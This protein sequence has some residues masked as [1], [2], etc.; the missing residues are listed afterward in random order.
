MNLS[1]M[2]DIGAVAPIVMS[3][4]N[5]KEM[6]AKYAS[7]K[8]EHDLV[9]AQTT[10]ILLK[11]M[12]IVASNLIYKYK[13]NDTPITTDCVSRFS[14]DPESNTPGQL[15]LRQSIPLLNSRSNQIRGLR[16]GNGSSS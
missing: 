8:S 16:I 2:Q 9:P 6:Q 1:R 5:V 12:A 13:S 11:T 3:V 14:L 4:A 10:L 7:S 15:P